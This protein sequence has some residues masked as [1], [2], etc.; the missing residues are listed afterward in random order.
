MRSVIPSVAAAA[1]VAVAVAPAW[2]QYQYP[3]PGG[4][5]EAVAVVD[6][7]YRAYLGRSGVE[8]GGSRF[9]SDRIRTG[10]PAD[11][12]EAGILGSDE[13]YG[14]HGNNL[15][16]WVRAV[17]RDVLG[18]PATPREADFWSR[19]AYTQGLE[20]IALEILARRPRASAV[21][22]PNRNW[23]G[24]PWPPQDYDYRR[25]YYPYRR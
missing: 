24:S 11:S 5:D 9:W 13:Y 1:I 18:R 25:P 3:V 21:P 6:R 22:M 2:T 10:V 8:D 16:A 14:R 17:Y 20:A 4:Y 23:D 19:R 15:D 7:W 12:V